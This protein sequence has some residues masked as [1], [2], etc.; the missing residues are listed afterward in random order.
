MKEQKYP[1]PTVLKTM[2]TGYFML[3]SI[4]YAIFLLASIVIIPEQFSYGLYEGFRSI[5]LYLFFFCFYKF[6]W[7]YIFKKDGEYKKKYGY[8]YHL[9]EEYQ[10]KKSKCLTKGVLILFSLAIV[11]MSTFNALNITH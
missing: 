10:N 7:D 5:S 6:G 1:E 9:N 4:G 11:I 2:I 3:T 8:C